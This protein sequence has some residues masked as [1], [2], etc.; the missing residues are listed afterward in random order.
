MPPCT[1]GSIAPTATCTIGVLTK[2]LI[3][4]HRPLGQ[5]VYFAWYMGSEP[6]KWFA[7]HLPPALP[8]T[9]C[10][11]QWQG[12]PSLTIVYRWRLIE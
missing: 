9:H 6:N 3:S 8:H 5:E 11:N 12:F 1:R 2:R 10:A 7:F 4:G